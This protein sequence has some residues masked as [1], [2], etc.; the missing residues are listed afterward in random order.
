[1]CADFDKLISICVQRDLKPII[2]TLAPLANYNHSFEICDKL[3]LFNQYLLSKY[4]TQYPIID[5][6]SQMVDPFGQI[7]SECFE[8]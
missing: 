3:L 5:I 6:W 7:N 8:W 2:T 1:M 4:E